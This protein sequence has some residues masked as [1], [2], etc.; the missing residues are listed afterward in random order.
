MMY[1]TFR[2]S[3]N[4]AETGSPPLKNCSFV[5]LQELGGCDIVVIGVCVSRCLGRNSVWICEITRPDVAVGLVSWC[6]PM[7]VMIESLDL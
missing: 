2:M 6:K 7:V 5:V 4:S 3:L 1:Y